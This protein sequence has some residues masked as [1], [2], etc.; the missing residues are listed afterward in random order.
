MSFNLLKK[1]D[2]RTLPRAMFDNKRQKQSQ[3]K[4]YL[5]SLLH[6]SIKMADTDTGFN[7]LGKKQ[8][9]GRF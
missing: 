2:R 7:N 9:F 4:S 6:I 8:T 3:L 1:M 5:L